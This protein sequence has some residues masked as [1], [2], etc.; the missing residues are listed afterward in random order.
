MVRKKSGEIFYTLPREKIRDLDSLPFPAYDLLPM[1][2]YPLHRIVSSR[3]CPYACSWCNS[4][5]LWGQ[6]FRQ[7][8][9]EMVIE[10][11]K[12]LLQ[13]YGKKIFVFGDNSLNINLS[14]LTTLC[15]LLVQENIR[16]LWSAS[17]RAD[18]MT[19]EV[20][21][22]MRKAGCYNVAIGIESANNEILKNMGKATTREKI[23]EGVGYL[24]EAGIEVLSQYVIGSPG[25]TLD[26]I[27]ESIAFAKN[28]GCD[29]INFYTVL[30]FRGTE[31]WKYIEKHGKFL[32]NHTHEMHTIKPRVVFETPE[33][34]YADRVEA[35]RLVKKEGF[36]SNKDKKSWL[37]D[38]AKDT[39]RMIQRFLPP[40]AGEKIYALMKSIYQIKVVKKNNL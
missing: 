12:H 26:T 6:S 23:L 31:Q 21:Q 34:P 35:I 14:W 10:E 15:D 40:G 38:L 2:R 5:S 33:F 11:I 20:A 25:D 7:R 16:I 29:Y 1:G 27:R 4:S 13:H 17:V 24:K 8:S 22:K 36:Y 37:F 30:P 28:S 3:G 39:A 18:L 19:R 32:V 9:P